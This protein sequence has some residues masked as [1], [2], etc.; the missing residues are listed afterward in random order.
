MKV[1]RVASDFLLMK[2]PPYPLSMSESC[3]RPVTLCMQVHGSLL[4]VRHLLEAHA[5]APSL[6]SS[7]AHAVLSETAALL[8]ERAWLATPICTASAVRA[9][10]LRAAGPLLTA[11]HSQSTDSRAVS[12]LAGALLGACQ[13]ALLVQEQSDN[14]SEARRQPMGAAHAEREGIARARRDASRQNAV[15][16]GCS[17]DRAAQAGGAELATAGADG[18]DAMH[19]V[20]LK[21]AALLFFSPA[22]RSL[23][24]SGTLGQ[25]NLCAPISQLSVQICQSCSKLHAAACWQVE[26]SIDHTEHCCRAGWGKD[27]GCEEALSGLRVA[28]VKSA[29]EHPLYDVRAATM[30]ALL[31]RSSGMLQ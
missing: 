19:S 8:L 24:V 1:P 7:E 22:L 13:E 15:S 17:D 31:A 6:Q 3:I 16:D 26:T 28:E 11:A 14:H 9:Q 18:A 5:H 27:Q 4:Q 23:A 29:L 10:F 20:L 21:E 12:A 2:S 25:P 30:K